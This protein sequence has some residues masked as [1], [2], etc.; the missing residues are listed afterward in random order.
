MTTQLLRGKRLRLTRL[1]DCC[2]PPADATEC[3]VVVTKGFISVTMT[4]EYEDGDEFIQ[5]NADGELCVNE[6]EEQELKR[7][8]VGLELCGVDFSVLDIVTG[9]RVEVN[10]A[11]DPV[12]VR[13]A[14]G[15]AANRFALEVWTGVGGSDACATGA[16]PQYGYFLL[17]CVGG[18][19][20]GEVVI[21]ND[22]INVTLEN[23]FTRGGGGWGVGPYNVIEASSAPSPLLVPMASDEHRLAR[24]TTIAPPP[25][26]DGCVPMYSGDAP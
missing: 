17:P 2:N 23:A 5:K 18:G 3:S 20:M 1:D 22:V 21:Q 14:T 26:T 7:L 16:D 8:T 9:D 15:K 10:D 12:G 24:L 6:S 13:S 25:V 19:K 11:G 4:P